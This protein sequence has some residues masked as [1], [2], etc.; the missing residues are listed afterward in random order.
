M[1]NFK[2]E[3]FCKHVTLKWQYKEAF[4]KLL[5]FKLRICA[6]LFTFTGYTFNCMCFILH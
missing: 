2:T 5:T 4:Y 3:A 1:N 6:W